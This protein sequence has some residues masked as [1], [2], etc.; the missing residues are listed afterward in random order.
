MQCAQIPFEGGGNMVID[1]NQEHHHRHKQWTSF[2][3]FLQSRPCSQLHG[4]AR[5]VSR[6]RNTSF[7]SIETS[8]W[9]PWLLSCRWII[10]THRPLCPF[11]LFPCF[12]FFTSICGVAPLR[13]KKVISVQIIDIVQIVNLWRLLIPENQACII[14][15]HFNAL[16]CLTT[17]YNFCDK[18]MVNYYKI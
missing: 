14:N 13:R 9:V 5:S 15:S 8:Q 16:V 3:F 2:L 4:F 7:I 10:Q 17:W 12:S 11:F 18:S 1:N 6:G